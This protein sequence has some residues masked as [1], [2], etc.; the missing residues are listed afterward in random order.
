MGGGTG[1]FQA[2]TTLPG[3][4]IDILALGS[5]ASIAVGTTTVAYSKSFFLTHGVTYGWEIKMGSSGPVAVTV[6]LE[7]SNQPP[8]TE[9]AQDDA[10]NIP[11]GKTTTNGLFPLGSIVA[12][13]IR[14]YTAYS[15]VATALGRLKFT[16]T[17]S[18]DASTVVNAARVYEI[19]NN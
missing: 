10:F 12:P 17:G 15:P 11:I 14:Y 19:K 18:N 1:A 4:L 16:G 6:E 7:Q 5:V 13:T 8:T 3:F 2:G 9:N